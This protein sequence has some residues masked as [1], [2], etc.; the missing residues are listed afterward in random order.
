MAVKEWN[1]NYPGSQDTGTNGENQMPDLVNTQDD[2]RVSQLHK[3]RNKLHAVA[4]KVGDN[5]NLP[6]G[7]LGA[8]VTTLENSTPKS[9]TILHN[10]ETEVEYGAET[11]GDWESA[12][13]FPL[14]VHDWS[15][16][17]RWVV[18]AETKF[19]G[20]YAASY[21]FRLQLTDESGSTVHQTL[22]LSGL[23]YSSYTLALV[24]AVSSGVPTGTPVYARFQLR[25]DD[26]QSE[27][28][29]RFRDITGVID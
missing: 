2:T 3:V 26:N 7:C 16:Y 20:L 15:P 17:T 19:N 8:R 12:D 21:D 24:M 22:T 10:A 27:V 6:A 29:I 23:T 28:K 1:T 4:L 13:I 25:C 18:A 9:R 5:N 14:Y 11:P